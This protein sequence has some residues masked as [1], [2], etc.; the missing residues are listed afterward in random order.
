M[1]PQDADDRVREGGTVDFGVCA[2]VPVCVCSVHLHGRHKPAE[3]LELLGEGR[4][5]LSPIRVE[6]VVAV[7]GLA[8]ALLVAAVD[9][10]Q[11]ATRP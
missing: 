9:H 7:N 6:G 2:H 10:G 3:V 11:D 1:L 8:G 5:H 4:V